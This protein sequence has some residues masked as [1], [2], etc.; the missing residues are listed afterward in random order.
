LTITYTLIC[1]QHK[2]GIDYFGDYYWS[3]TKLDRKE[4]VRN[5][6]GC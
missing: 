1:L 4:I 5:Q 6:I 2:N 3:E